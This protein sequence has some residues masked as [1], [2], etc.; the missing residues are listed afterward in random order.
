M[1]GGALP[2][3]A[4]D[5][6]AAAR[7]TCIENSQ[8]RPLRAKV[9]PLDALQQRP[10]RRVPPRHVHRLLAPLRA[11]ARARALP[12]R[13]ELRLLLLRHLG[14]RDATRRSRSARSAGACSASASSSSA[15]R[16]TTGSAAPLPAPSTPATRKALLLVSVV[17]YLGVLSLFKYCELRRRHRAH[18]PRDGRHRTSTV[19]HLRLVLPFGISFFT[20]ET[21][22][23]TIDVYR[24]E[25]EP[26]RR[27]LDYLLFVCFFPHLVAGPIVRPRQMLPQ[28]AA[29]AGRGP[30]HAG[31]RPLAHR[32]GAREEDRA[33][34]TPLG[35]PRRPRLRQPRALLVRSSSWSPSTRTPSRSTATSPATPTSPSAARSSSATELPENFNAPYLARNLQDFWHRWHISLSTWLRDYLY[36]PLGGSRRGRSAPT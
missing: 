24:R 7:D 19:A 12:R 13:R 11:T 10:L 15:A 26:A 33:S 9:R 25:L 8:L 2:A 30:R 5:G 6:S 29:R 20:F 17:Y 14:R 27:Y 22:S 16:S 35:Q 4:G 23:Y 32:H 31:T 28:L 36:V 1:G 34:A 21:M 18:G 3:L